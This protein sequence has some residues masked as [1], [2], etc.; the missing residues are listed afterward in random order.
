MEHPEPI[1][2]TSCVQCRGTGKAQDDT[3]CLACQGTG[4]VPA[5]KQPT[6]PSTPS[7]ACSKQRRFSRY[8][9]DLPITIRD[10]AKRESVGRCVII[11]EGGLAAI[12][13][14]PIPTGSLVVVRLALP[15]HPAILELMAIV[16]NQTGLRHGLEFISMA[17][18]EG[19]AIGH[20]CAGLVLQSE[21]STDSG[22]I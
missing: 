9:T 22:T 21:S 4:L 19:E 2:R 20:F 16:R 1:G 11:A 15:N 14:E 18:S 8:H 10:Q 6:I 5:F 12:F 7:S 17:D 13:P 3:P